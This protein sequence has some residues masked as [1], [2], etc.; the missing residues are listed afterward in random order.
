MRVVRVAMPA[1]V[2][3]VAHCANWLAGSPS[4]ARVGASPGAR[5]RLAKPACGATCAAG[6]SPALSANL[7]LR[8]PTAYPTG[9]LPERSH[10]GMRSQPVYVPASRPAGFEQCRGTE[11]PSADKS[12]WHNRAGWNG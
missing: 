3:S 9:G 10:P 4:R 1:M 12:V 8:G 11:C 2:A 5:F 6:S 7:A